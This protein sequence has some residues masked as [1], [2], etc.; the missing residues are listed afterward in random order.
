MSEID[1]V[2]QA[3]LNYWYFYIKLNFCTPLCNHNTIL[4]KLVEIVISCVKNYLYLQ[5]V[6]LV[7][8]IIFVFSSW[9]IVVDMA[10]HMYQFSVHVSHATQPLV[11]KIKNILSD[12]LH[13]RISL[14]TNINHSTFVD[15][16]EY[17]N[18]LDLYPFPN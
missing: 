16:K 12:E 9:N 7:M 10:A 13:S 18:P 14:I 15:I 2:P 17:I 1:Y 8:T 6:I 11:Y 3:K 4:S 5:C